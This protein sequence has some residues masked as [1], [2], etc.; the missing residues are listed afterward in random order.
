MS[1]SPSKT[2]AVSVQPTETT[3]QEAKRVA[4]ASA[5]ARCFALSSRRDWD[6]AEDIERTKEFVE[7]LDMENVR[8]ALSDTALFT[9]RRSRISARDF[10]LLPRRP[11]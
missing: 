3:E 4:F 7:E 11:V 8:A 6:L 2:S 1:T 5:V 9:D 10:V